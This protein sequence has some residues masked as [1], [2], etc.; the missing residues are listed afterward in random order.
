MRLD[1]VKNPPEEVYRKLKSLYNIHSY[2]GNVSE[3]FPEC[4]YGL[5]IEKF[6]ETKFPLSW[7]V[8]KTLN[9]LLDNGYMN[10]SKKKYYNWLGNTYAVKREYLDFN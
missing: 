5:V 6:D 1:S 2:L 10:G 7:K 9:D 8:T 4:S 3:S